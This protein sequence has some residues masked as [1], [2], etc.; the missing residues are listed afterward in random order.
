LNSICPNVFSTFTLNGLDKDCKGNT[1]EVRSGDYNTFTFTN[2]TF[3]IN[4]TSKSQILEVIFNPGSTQKCIGALK[5][6]IPVTSVIDS[7]PVITGCPIESFIVGMKH[8]I[9]MSAFLKQYKIGTN[10]QE[11]CLKYE[12]SIFSGGNGW[13]LNPTN[14]QNTIGKNLNIVT[15]NCS[16]GVIQVVGV[17]KC[18]TRSNPAYCYILRDIERP[19]ISSTNLK[20]YVLCCNKDRITLFANQKTTGLSGYTYTWNLG[21]W[22]G[23]NSGNDVRI[24]PSGNSSGNFILTTSACGIT[25]TKQYNIPLEKIDP[26]I[27]VIGDKYLCSNGTYQLNKDLETCNKVTWSVR[28]PERVLKP[29]GTGEIAELIANITGEATIVFKIETPCGTVEKVKDFYVGKPVLILTNYDFTRP[30][31][32]NPWEEQHR[33]D[34]CPS[35][36]DPSH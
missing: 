5:F 34:I 29:A 23:E 28:P 27:S 16:S 21:D 36:K 11:E 25:T 12:W 17:D 15:D 2:N 10:D 7:T 31:Y 33:F 22:T 30:P 35:L 14:G 1:F 24:Y 3:T 4:P 6:T 20:G 32:P 18:G 13:I 8:N 19:S 9:N 26:L